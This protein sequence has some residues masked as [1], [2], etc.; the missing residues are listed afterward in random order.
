MSCPFMFRYVNKKALQGKLHAQSRNTNS[1]LM[2]VR[3]RW[4]PQDSFTWH[5]AL[6]SY[7]FNKEQSMMIKEIVK[8]LSGAESEDNRNDTA[9][10]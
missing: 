8:T 9:S 4:E 3:K 10:S 2:G 1:S 6:L 5:L 7:M